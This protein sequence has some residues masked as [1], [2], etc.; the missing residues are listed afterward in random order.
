MEYGADGIGVI[1]DFMGLYRIYGI[2]MRF[3]WDLIGFYRI[4]WDIKGDFLGYYVI[5]GV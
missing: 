2:F 5:I 1:G 3:L 4:Y